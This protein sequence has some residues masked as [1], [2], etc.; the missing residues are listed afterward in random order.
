MSDNNTPP[1]D[2]GFDQERDPMIAER[3]DGPA[4]AAKKPS[5]GQEMK[6]N[7]SAVFG[8][9]LG[10][11]AIILVVVVVLIFIALGINGMT[12]KKE[13]TSNT[14]QVDS[15]RAPQPE[16]SID[17]VSESEAQRRKQVS[18]QEAQKAAQAGS[19]YQPGFDP[20]I[21]ESTDR[22]YAKGQNAQFRVPGQPYSQQNAQPQQQVYVGAGQQGGQYGAQ[23]T[24]A[25]GTAQAQAQ[26]QADER[27]RVEEELKQAKAARDKY[28]ADLKAE[29]LK[30]IKTI[31]GEDEGSKGFTGGKSSSFS[32]VTYY[33]AQRNTSSD[34]AQSDRIAAKSEK[35]P[36]SVE[37]VGDTDRELLIKTGQIMYATLDAEINTDDGGDVLATVR[38]G[39]WNGSKL[40]GKYEQAPDNIRVRFTV[41]APPRK[42]PRP[43]MRINAI[44][45]REEDAKQGMAETKDY[46][47]LQRY[48]ALGAAALLTGY[49]RA[50]QQYEGTTVISPSGVVSQTTTEPSQKR[51]IGNVV[52]ELGSSVGSEVRRGFNRPPTY[53]TPANKGFGVF[54]MQDVHDQSR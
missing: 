43:T 7:L 22:E 48:G 2:S 8:S 11:V 28:V 27:K 1:N 52:G 26:A 38:G 25:Q 47:L 36:G 37:A 6:R 21:V 12:S 4:V 19:S 15:P 30:S 53:A 13:A 40:I 16:V 39:E 50:Y 10:K 51:V 41:L 42:D 17:P 34:Q 45:L 31:M 35:A 44:A 24:A 14:A 32:T 20:N 3:D 33:P 5:K 23:Q 9:G 29:T 46:H 18:A 49:G 54:F